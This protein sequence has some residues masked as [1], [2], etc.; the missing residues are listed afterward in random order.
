MPDN[1]DYYTIQEY[2]LNGDS[3]EMTI[4]RPGNP[5]GVTFPVN[6]LKSH[7]Q[8]GT[9]ALKHNLSPQDVYE[10]LDEGGLTVVTELP[11]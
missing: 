3:V 11:Q 7:G 5:E 8:E 2:A 1:D 9:I 6:A 4:R 10:F